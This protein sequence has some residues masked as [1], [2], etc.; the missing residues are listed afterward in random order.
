MKVYETRGRFVLGYEAN[1]QYYIPVRGESF[2]HRTG[3]NLDSVNL[4]G[5]Y[6]YKTR[7]GAV[8]AARKWAEGR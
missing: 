3:R 4:T 2:T 7:S 6:V 8:R 1:G 5:A